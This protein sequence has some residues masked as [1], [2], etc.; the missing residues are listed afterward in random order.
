[1]R[2]ILNRTSTTRAITVKTR[3]GPQNMFSI[4]IFRFLVLVDYY[5]LVGSDVKR[6]YSCSRQFFFIVFCISFAY[7]LGI[8]AIHYEFVTIRWRFTRK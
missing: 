2:T 6:T 5:L 4:P 7:S 8:H 3:I 1:M